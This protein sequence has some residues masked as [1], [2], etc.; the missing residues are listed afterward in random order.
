MSNSS[1]FPGSWYRLPI[2]STADVRD[3]QQ[4]TNAYFGNVSEDTTHCKKSRH[5][6]LLGPKQKGLMR[7]C[8][9]YRSRVSPDKMRHRTAWFSIYEKRHARHMFVVFSNV[10]PHTWRRQAKLFPT[11]GNVR[12]YERHQQ[13][14]D[15]LPALGAAVV[16]LAGSFLIDNCNIFTKRLACVSG[17]ERR[18]KLGNV[19]RL[20]GK[21][22]INGKGEHNTNSCQYTEPQLKL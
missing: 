8:Y 16:A 13:T 18:P 2:A 6:C 20:N 21:R 1:V 19:Y 7:N 14:N 12:F 3:K 10:S 9:T 17:R 15:T 22:P 4:L 11:K 5:A